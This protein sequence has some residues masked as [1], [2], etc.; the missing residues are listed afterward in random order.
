MGGKRPTPRRARCHAR[1]SG[2][3]RFCVTVGL[4][5]IVI[6]MR[7]SSPSFSSV[8]G[9]VALHLRGPLRW[10]GSHS[11]QFRISRAASNLRVKHHPQFSENALLDT[12]ARPPTPREE[13]R[14][15]N[16]V[17][18]ALGH[19]HT[20]CSPHLARLCTRDTRRAHATHRPQRHYHLS[21]RRKNIEQ[22]YKLWSRPRWRGHPTFFSLRN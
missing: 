21:Q 22:I 15:R 20:P 9:H 16:D 11:C 3:F 12:R 17:R 14:E 10:R 1:C 4:I 2:L 6:L 8:R 13:S 18:A 7:Y 19:A 5:E